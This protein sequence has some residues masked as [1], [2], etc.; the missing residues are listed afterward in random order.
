M[1]NFQEGVKCPPGHGRLILLI[2]E[3]NFQPPDSAGGSSSC[4]FSPE[5]LANF[6]GLQ[7]II[8]PLELI[9][10]IESTPYPIYLVCISEVKF[11]Q[12]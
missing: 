10:Y 5:R 7:K 2:L 11:K 6:C 9:A 8:F 1:A 12:G 4:G 3:M